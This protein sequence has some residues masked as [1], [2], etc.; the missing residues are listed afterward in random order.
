MTLSAAN[1]RTQILVAALRVLDGQWILVA[2]ART[3]S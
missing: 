2:I 1:R 3:Y